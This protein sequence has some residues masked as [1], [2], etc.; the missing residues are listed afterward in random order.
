MYQIYDLYKITIYKNKIIKFVLKR[1]QTF[2]EKFALFF[3]TLLPLSQKNFLIITTHLTVA[4]LGKT[5]IPQIYSPYS[6]VVQCTLLG[7]GE[8]GGTVLPYEGM[9]GKASV[10]WHMRQ[11]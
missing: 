4:Y 9:F 6:T 1:Y 10:C 11:A 3:K 7:V 8:G 2:T 5:G